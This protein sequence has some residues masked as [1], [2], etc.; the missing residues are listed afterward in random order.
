MG[1]KHTN[2]IF[3]KGGM[4]ETPRSDLS[5]NYEELANWI[6]GKTGVPLVDANMKEISQTG[7]MSNRGRQIVAS[8]L[9]NDLKVNWQM[10]AVRM[11]MEASLDFRRTERADR[12]PKSRLHEHYA[13]LWCGLGRRLSHSGTVHLD[14]RLRALQSDTRLLQELRQE[15]VAHSRCQRCVEDRAM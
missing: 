7:F 6:L 9:I 12:S 2:K 15:D 8:F 4:K 1:K 10:G 11:D 5:D 13:G 14:L 3:L